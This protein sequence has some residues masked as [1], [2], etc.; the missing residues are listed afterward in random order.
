[1]G[2]K[3]T[4]D[5]YKEW[6]KLYID[7]KS[8]KE[9]GDM[10]KADP[11]HVRRILIQRGVASKKSPKC[12]QEDFLIWEKLYNEGN[13]YLAIS[14]LYQVSDSYVR[15]TLKNRG[16]NSRSRF[17]F[18]EE[19]INRWV[20]LYKQGTPLSQL[21]L[22]YKTEPTTIK[23]YIEPHLELREN[24]MKI[25]I[26]ERKKWIELYENGVSTIEIGKQYNV[27]KETVR[28]FLI[29]N[30]VNT[31]KK[32]PDDLIAEWKIKHMQGFSLTKIAESYNVDYKTV[33]S[34][35]EDQNFQYQIKRV[36]RKDTPPEEVVERWKRL[37]ES[38]KSID[39]FASSECEDKRRIRYFLIKAGVVLRTMSEAKLSKPHLLNAEPSNIKK[40]VIVGSLLGDGCA[41]KRG[42]LLIGHSEKQLEWLEQKA[43]WLGD[44]VYDIGIK[45][46][47]RDRY[48]KGSIKYSLSTVPNQFIKKLREESYSQNGERDISSLIPLIEPLALAVLIGDDGSY[49][50]KGEGVGNIST[51]GFSENQNALLVEHLQTKF[52]ID[53]KVSKA[54]KKEKVYYHIYIRSSGMNVLRELID[55]YLPDSMKYKIGVT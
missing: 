3:Y 31:S 32:V 47:I 18:S 4:K 8:Y 20:E 37:Y 10:Y 9:I 34:H 14:K 2:V 54:R 12:T 29:K 5:T 38:G 15:R 49:V 6:D 43:E 23:K 53:C 30:G 46:S 52:N 33:K 19:D 40:Q 22:D 28:K 44:L 7:G 35:F 16:V 55:P 21:S 24:G 42:R 26:K 36:I 51:H 25:S 27:S 39:K 1:M 48:K 13:S 50:K 41:D 45:R 17:S 11:S